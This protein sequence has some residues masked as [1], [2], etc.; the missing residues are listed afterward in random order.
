MTQITACETSNTAIQEF[1]YYRMHVALCDVRSCYSFPFLI[2]ITL[3]RY[4]IDP[5]GKILHRRTLPRIL[6]GLK[7]LAWS[8]AYSIAIQCVPRICCKPT[9]AWIRRH[10]VN[11]SFICLSY[12]LYIS[13]IILLSSTKIL[14]LFSSHYYYIIHCLFIITIMLILARC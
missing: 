11:I 14:L 5:N 12:F 9:N 13:I 7:I 3:S 1:S 2:S 8:C 4:Y 10:F 6:A